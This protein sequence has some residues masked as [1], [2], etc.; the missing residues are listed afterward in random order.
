[1]NESDFGERRGPVLAAARGPLPLK[2]GAQVHQNARLG[3]HDVQAASSVTR[4]Q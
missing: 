4:A 1:M 3:T 2:F